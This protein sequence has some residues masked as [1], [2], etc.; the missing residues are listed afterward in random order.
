MSKTAANDDRRTQAQLGNAREQE[1]HHI[2]DQKGQKITLGND[3]IKSTATMYIRGCEDT[4]IIFDAKCTKI[5]IEGCRRCSV[6]LKGRVL[7]NIVEVWKCADF[8]LG[9]TADIKTMQ[10][11]ICR[12]L[13]LNF[14]T[15]DH[16]S[17]IV[18]AGVYNLVINVKDEPD[19]VPYVSGYDQMKLQYTD[20]NPIHDQFIVRNLKGEI[21]SEQVVRLPNGYPTT[22]REAQE[23]DNNAEQN[24]KNAEEF[25]RKR[26]EDAGVRLGRKAAEGPKTG[27]NDPCTCGSGKKAKKCCQAK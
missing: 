2:R 26:L 5:M 16:V 25:V 27:R 24:A 1:V 18:W 10:L 22:E 11:D 8:T 6:H 23:F 14:D 19:F 21:T 9:V 20:L 15:K 3:D 7:T 4:E 12:N 17:N 13:T